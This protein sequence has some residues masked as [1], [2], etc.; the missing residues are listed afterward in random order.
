MVS[1]SASVKDIR[2]NVRSALLQGVLL[3]LTIESNMMMDNT[4]P[5]INFSIIFKTETITGRLH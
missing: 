2:P 5:A 3:Q 4:Y 1:A